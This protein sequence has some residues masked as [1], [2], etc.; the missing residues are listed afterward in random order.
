M[1][2]K[3]LSLTEH[4]VLTNSP[5]ILIVD[6]SESDRLSYV[7]YLESD[8]GRNY[9]I[10]EAKTLEE[11][12]EL[13]RSQQPDVVLLDI[14]L[15]DGD[16]LEFLEAI[17]TDQ[18]INKLPVIMLAGQGDERIAVRAMKLGAADYLVKDDVIAISLLTAISQVQE[19]DLLLRQ[20]RRSQHQQTLIA[21]MALT[22]V[23][24]L[25]LK[26]LLIG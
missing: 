25:T 3:N 24:L 11:G 2:F 7:R 16:G 1:E 19:N 8:L 10:I 20:L 4:K 14:N 6:D 21:S 12:L 15:P 5:K 22:S 17:G 23:S 18:L 9:H 13:W 26:M